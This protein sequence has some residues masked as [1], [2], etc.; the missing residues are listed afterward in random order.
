MDANRIEQSLGEQFR[1]L[2][3]PLHLVDKD[4]DLVDSELVKEVA[5]F[6]KFLA[7]LNVDI[8]LSKAV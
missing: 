3:S 4:N 2:L 7:L 1:Q 6:F 5:Q 8:I